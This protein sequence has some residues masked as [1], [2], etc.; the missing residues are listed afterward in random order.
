MRR[1]GPVLVTGS[2]G[3]IGRAL[4]GQLDA[5]G[6]E[7]R[8]F[9]AALGGDVRDADAVRAATSGV[10][11]VIHL[12]G[13]MHL[14]PEFGSLVMDVNLRGTF[15]VLDAAREHGVGRVVI[16][17][18]VQASGVFMG[19]RAPDY[20]PLD[21]DHPSYPTIPYAMAKW[22][23]EQMSAH[24]TRAHGMVTVCLRPPTVYTPAVYASRAEI[25]RQL[26]EED[27][28]LWNYGTW[29]DVRDVAAAFRLCIDADIPEG[30]LTAFVTADDVATERS[31]VEI[32]RAV[33]P[34]VP[35]RCEADYVAEPRRSQVDCSRLK[36]LTGWQ[37]VHRW[38]GASGAA[39][40]GVRGSADDARQGRIVAE[41]R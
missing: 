20:L 8:C 25:R 22:L 27:D 11:A 5:A 19:E 28:A 37:P 41:P 10:S 13:D 3:G 12:A 16:A 30:H 23:G 1:A 9:D 31:G 40:G 21:D 7:V 33:Y 17:S 35:W 18:S 6:V 34:D 36:R 26:V 38:P 32:T 4:L 15:N 14:D 39:A 2:E 29:I 24:Y